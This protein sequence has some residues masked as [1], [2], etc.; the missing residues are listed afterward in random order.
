M[1]LL[2]TKHRL[3]GSMQQVGTSG[4]GFSDQEDRIEVVRWSVNNLLAI[5]RGLEILF[6]NKPL[7]E[8]PMCL[9]PNLAVLRR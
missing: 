5:L 9:T 3:T 7:F 4:L 6:G 2:T 8:G 1:T